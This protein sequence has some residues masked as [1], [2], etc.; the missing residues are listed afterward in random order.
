MLSDR[1]ARQ[2]LLR[3]RVIV[4]AD[5]AVRRSVR[6]I[7]LAA[8]NLL[9][10]FGDQR[11]ARVDGLLLILLGLIYDVLSLLLHN[12]LT[13]VVAPALILHIGQPLLALSPLDA[14]MRSSE[15]ATGVT[16]DG[17]GWPLDIHRLLRLVGVRDHHTVILLVLQDLNG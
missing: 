13:R 9:L 3:R 16:G 11:R 6:A 10:L 15:G 8:Q 4:P 1:V 5:W 12:F 7:L 17:R 14:A 2:V